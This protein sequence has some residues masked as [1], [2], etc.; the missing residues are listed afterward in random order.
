MASD[1]RG[2]PFCAHIRYTFY[3]MVDDPVAW[4]AAVRSDRPL[5]S[6]R[7]HLWAFIFIAILLMLTALLLLG[8]RNEANQPP[9]PSTTVSGTPDRES[10][11]YTISY[12]FGVFSPTNLRIHQGDTVRWHNDGLLPVRVAAQLQTTGKAPEFDSVG[13]IPPDGYFSYTFSNVGVFT[14]SNH[15]NSK[16]QGVIIVREP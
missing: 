13:T 7:P 9:T 11:V 8:P 1:C 4:L 2:V 12:R 15:E 10:R 16:E 5:P 3:T 14:Y 6:G